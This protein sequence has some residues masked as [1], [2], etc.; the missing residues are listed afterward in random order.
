MAA[1]PHAGDRL[2]VAV[3]G[4]GEAGREIAG[5]LAARGHDVRGYDPAAGGD[6][7]QW[8]RAETPEEAVD[9]CDTVLVLVAAEVAYQVAASV[10]RALAPGM[11]YADCC[12]GDPQVKRTVAS[13]VEETGAAFVDVALLAPVPGRGLATP[14][15]LSGSGAEQFAKL[16]QPLGLPVEIVS[17]APGD[18]A[19]R[20][21]LRS[22]F[23]KGMATA[24]LEA[25]EAA[26]TQHCG[27]WL[28]DNIAAE[29][30]RAD[31]ALIERLITGSKVHARRRVDEMAA[32]E[33]LLHELS[34]DA[35]V[36]RASKARL[37]LLAL[38]AE[39]AQGSGRK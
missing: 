20:K 8:R 3:M 33:N 23:M 18:A 9:G 37:E 28:R 4:L 21:L 12:T 27:E 15:L 7:G 29:L 6:E 31:G 19:A 30:E 13:A 36:T 11:V 34:V 10:S 5:D 25:L 32:A 22:V 16:F 24:L 14:T 35:G 39:G 2:R 1:S 17:A 38:A 26:E